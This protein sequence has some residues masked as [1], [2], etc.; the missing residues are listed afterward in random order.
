MR[1]GTTCINIPFD[2][3]EGKASGVVRGTEFRTNDKVTKGNQ[4]C[5]RFWKERKGVICIEHRWFWDEQREGV[6]GKER[7]GYKIRLFDR[8][9]FVGMYTLR[10]ETKGKIEEV[11]CRRVCVAKRGKCE[12]KDEERGREF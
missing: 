5:T 10:R 8:K 1:R 9:L 11:V 6:S 3:L 2:F 12:K 7:G 4:V